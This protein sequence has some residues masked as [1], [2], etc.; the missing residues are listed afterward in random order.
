MQ[1]IDFKADKTL[2]KGAF[3]T[4]TGEPPQTAKLAQEKLAQKEASSIQQQEEIIEKTQLDK[5]KEI[6]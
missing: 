2:T 4:I 5:N 1:P 3:E 6:L